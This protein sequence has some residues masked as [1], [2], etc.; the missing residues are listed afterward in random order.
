MSRQIP[1]TNETMK[2]LQSLCFTTLLLLLPAGSPAAET[3]ADTEKTVTVTIDYGGARPVRSV[4]T[5]YRPGINA[6]QLLQ[7]VAAVKTYRLGEHT[8]IRSIDGLEGKRGE[9]GWFYSVDGVSAKRVAG[10]RILTDA[11]RMTWRYKVAA[12]Y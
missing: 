8:F 12:C 4:T 5:A 9:M 11:E 2:R 6:L 10:K 1:K 7:Q 3:T